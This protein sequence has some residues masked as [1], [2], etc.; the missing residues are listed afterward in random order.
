M[1][2]DTLLSMLRY[3]SLYDEFF[4]E[5][6]EE[7]QG[8]FYLVC[9]QKKDCLCERAIFAHNSPARRSILLLFIDLLTF[10][11]LVNIRALSTEHTSAE[12]QRPNCQR[13][14]SQSRLSRTSSR[15]HS[16]MIGLDSATSSQPTNRVVGRI[17]FQST[18]KKRTFTYSL[19]NNTHEPKRVRHS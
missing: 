3:F 15:W 9:Q 11:I 4:E 7:K 18:V 19:W 8:L 6:E 14:D 1:L 10:F 16:L 12:Y 13:L 17:L 5:S 2:K